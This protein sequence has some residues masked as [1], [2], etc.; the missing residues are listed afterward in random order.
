MSPL[1][2]FLGLVYWATGA[3]LTGFAGRTTY[4]SNVGAIV[5]ERPINAL[6]VAGSLK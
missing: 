3:F 5:M 4:F 2:I 6:V 1:S